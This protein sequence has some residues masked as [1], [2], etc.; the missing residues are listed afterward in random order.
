MNSKK[1]MRYYSFLL[2][3]L[4]YLPIYAQQDQ[5]SGNVSDESG[6][7]LPGVSVIVK[8]TS[9]G[10]A[11]DFDGNFTLNTS[12]TATLV[13]S[14]LGYK[15]QEIGLN[16]K[17]VLS[18]VMIEEAGQ[19]DEVVVV[20]YGSVKKSDLTGSVTSIATEQITE[21]N[22]NNPVEAIQ[23]NLPGVTI[24]NNSGRLGDGFSVNI[25][26]TNSFNS[27]EP[28]YIVDGI[29]TGGIDFLNPQD[30]ERIDVLKDASSAAIYGSRG[31][32]G[33][34]IV[35]TK[36]GSSAKP[37]VT[38]NVE[39]SYG[40]VQA[41]RMP[42]FMSGEEWW[43]Y[44]QVAYLNQSNPLGDTPE[45]NLALAGNASPELIKRANAGYQFDWGD[46]VIKDGVIQ[47][48]YVSIA[49]RADNGL[50][51]NLGLG[52]QNDEGL[53]E[54]ESIDKYTFK[55]AVNHRI[56][57][58][59]S[60]GVNI[61]ISHQIDQLGSDRAMQE[62]LRLNPLTS[63]WAIDQDGNQ[64]VGELF[65]QPGKLTYPDGSWA[66]NKTSTINPLVEIANSSQEVRRWKTIGNIFLEYRPLEWLSFKTAYSAGMA[67]YRTGEAYGGESNVGNSRGGLPSSEIN[68]YQNFN[69]TWDNQFNIN[70][71]L[72]DVHVFNFLGLQSLY[73][74]RT[75]TSFLSSF[76]QPFETDWYNIG[77]GS[78]STFNARSNF[79]KNTLSSYAVRLNYSLMDKYL[80]T[81]SN[82]WDGSSVLAEGNKWN[83]FPSVA[84]AW[85]LSEESFL[86]QSS[87]VSNLKARISLG[88][89]GN[90]NVGAYSSLNGIP[91][92][93]YYDY[94]G[95]PANGF[96]SNQL[97]N[98]N[99]GWEKTRELNF[100]VDFGFLNNRII[101]TLDIYD[102]LSEDL[103]A[104]QVLPIESGAGT[105]K[106]NVGSISNKGVEVSLTTRNISTEKVSWETSFTFTKNKNALE[107]VYNQS[108][109][110]DIGNGFFIGQ[111]L[112]PHYNYVFDGVWQA[113][114]A[115]EAASYNMK[116]GQA[117]PKDINGD[118]KITADGDRVILG[119]NQP[120]WSG[121]FTSNLR[122]GSFDLSISAITSQGVL[123]LSSFHDNFADTSDRGRQKIAF[124]SYYVPE[125]GAGLPV[126][127]SNTNPRPRGEG[128]YWGTNFAFYRDASFVKIKN[129]AFGYTL[130]RKTIDKLK[131]K[132]CRVYANILN[133][134]VFTDYDGWDPEWASA[135]LGTG[136]PSSITYQLGISLQL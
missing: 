89:T 73:S 85:K 97:A 93:T 72:N 39:S 46:A 55:G 125:N 28:L 98:K 24:S 119:T 122:V 21:R 75:E 4:F 48:N 79:V 51:Y 17:K 34:I 120:D 30:I 47:N 126:Q 83:S 58:K 90:D 38:V 32:S 27:T 1:S 62:A 101:G 103:I 16:G 25:R 66:F 40:I 105:T 71:T 134:F 68:N 26:G 61:T 104:D 74:N 36:G 60:T 49:G 111:P 92:Q 96:I 84:L 31:A 132:K 63:P 59:F 82:R 37:G 69:Y 86:N 95:V 45:N 3:I 113:D 9:T 56:N 23:G 130:N 19:L 18:I 81:V 91:T 106:A 42:D 35:T 78:Q 70:Y 114:E 136:R 131:I 57:D 20:G 54:K 14:Y 121:G 100:G 43:A 80:L 53:L 50:A 33:V 15:K 7:P 67:N 118:G 13:F 11:T 135:G 110:D 41:A 22:V 128:A 10:T 65:F 127:Y 87:F 133:P 109:V 107:S 8:G 44:H 12:S 123:A 76:E 29:P 64:L 102:R 99:L 2:G 52:M 94:N 117:R 6:I 129:I 5:I 112:N 115:D 77:S 88:Y 124:D 116:E 108:E